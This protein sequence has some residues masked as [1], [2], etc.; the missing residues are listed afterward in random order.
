MNLNTFRQNLVCYWRPNS[1]F[2][3]ARILAVAVLLGTAA[4]GPVAATLPA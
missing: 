3:A 4:A 1:Q 2:E